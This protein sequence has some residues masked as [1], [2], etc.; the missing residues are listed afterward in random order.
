VNVETGILRYRAALMRVVAFT[1]LLSA[2]APVPATDVQ[3]NAAAPSASLLCEDTIKAA[4]ASYADVARAIA[5]SDAGDCVV[6][7][8][9]TA[10]WAGGISI[11]GISLIGPGSTAAAPMT[12]TAGTITLTKHPTNVTRFIGVRYTGPGQFVQVSGGRTNKMA[13]I[14]DVYAEDDSNGIFVRVETYGVLFSKFH[15][16][17]LNH[18]GADTIIINPHA[19]DWNLGQTWGTNDKNGETNVYF[20][21]GSFAMPATASTSRWP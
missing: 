10:S 4:S 8:A 11:S 16:L 21:D 2:Q 20:E 5:A 13:V 12:I 15:F 3:V 14:H 1:V 9:G 7:P 6:V 19:S 18:N 17:N